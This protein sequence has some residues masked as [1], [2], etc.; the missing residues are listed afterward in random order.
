MDPRTRIRRI[1]AIDLWE[2]SIVTFPMLTG[3]RVRS[4]KGAPRS[5]PRINRGRI[6]RRTTDFPKTRSLP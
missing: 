2:I 3:G 4:V 6:Y 1:Y 5:P